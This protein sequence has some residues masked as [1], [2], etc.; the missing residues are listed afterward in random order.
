VFSSHPNSEDKKGGEGGRESSSLSEDEE[1]WG[2]QGLPRAHV[3][4]EPTMPSLPERRKALSIA[5]G[6]R[7]DRRLRAAVGEHGRKQHEAAASDGREP[8]VGRSRSP[9]LPPDGEHGLE[10]HEVVG[11]H[12]TKHVRGGLVCRREREREREGEGGRDVA[13]LH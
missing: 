8:G 7:S 11:I 6:S 10:H 9:G 2:Q 4:D 13:R 12:G 3:S 5:K 1:G